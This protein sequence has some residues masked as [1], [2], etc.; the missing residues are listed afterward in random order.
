MKIKCLGGCREV[1]R[2]AFL[3]QGKESILFDYGLKV[4]SSETP[5]PVEK[6][7]NII[8][9]HGHLDHCGSLPMLYKKFKNV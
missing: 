5:Q 1:G 4:E 9:G 8:L 7:D 3:V 2:N 6:V